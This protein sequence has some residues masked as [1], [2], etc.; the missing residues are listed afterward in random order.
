[1]KE[2]TGG[3][4][5]ILS[6]FLVLCVVA[7]L[8]AALAEPGTL[9][10]SLYSNTVEL[11]TEAPI[12]VTGEVGNVSFSS[13]NESAVTVTAAGVIS[14]VALGEAIITVS[15]ESGSDP[16]VLT[17]T[18][19]AESDK[20]GEAL[21]WSLDDGLLTVSG[22]GAMT[23]WTSPY[24]VPWHK[25]TADITEA[26]I[27]FG[28]QSIGTNAFADCSSLQKVTVYSTV[29][30]VGSGAFSG[31][32]ALNEVDYMGPQSWWGSVAGKEEISS[33]TLV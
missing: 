26:V 14:A 32:T 30:S 13:D 1:M 4:K 18:V 19:V 2:A 20:A 10:A 12:V 28:A 7:S 27:E 31:C 33:A 21:L 15:D 6:L 17:I 11:G 16:V 8:T 22:T 25:H 29:T 24:A 9:Q 5:R 3:T 23:E